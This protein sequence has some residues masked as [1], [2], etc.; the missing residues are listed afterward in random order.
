M[1]GI[2][3]YQ[4]KYYIFLRSS[5]TACCCSVVSADQL[6]NNSFCSGV[7]ETGFSPSSKNWDSVI[8]I[9]LHIFSIFCNVGTCCFRYQDEIVDCDTP[10]YFASSYSVQF[11]FWRSLVISCNTSFTPPPTY[12]VST[13][14][15]LRLS[16][17]FSSF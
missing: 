10:Q 16:L 4:Q 11:R 1:F 3:K 9:P 5:F 8:P 17:I 12:F 6:S 13:Y 2:T 15:I 7:S 14:I